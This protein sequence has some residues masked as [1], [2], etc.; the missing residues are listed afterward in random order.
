MR[1][2]WIQWPLS[3]SLSLNYQALGSCMRFVVPR[4]LG[5]RLWVL[6]MGIG[7]LALLAASCTVGPDYVT[8]N[9]RVAGQWMV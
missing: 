8:P 5:I 7:A 2:A 6:A 4:E 9:A 3:L 1:L